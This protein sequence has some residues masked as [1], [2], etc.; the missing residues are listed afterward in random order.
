MDTGMLIIVLVIVIPGYVIVKRLANTFYSDNPKLEE[1]TE[2][3]Y[4]F[5]R[6]ENEIIEKAK[7]KEISE[8]QVKHSDHQRKKRKRVQI[9]KKVDAAVVIKYRLRVKN[10]K[11]TKENIKQK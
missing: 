1:E 9:P 7:E 4:G 11:L 8:T 6:L 5:Q 3:R 10:E 2:R